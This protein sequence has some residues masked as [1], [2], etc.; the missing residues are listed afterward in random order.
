MNHHGPGDIGDSVSWLRIPTAKCFRND[1]ILIIL[2]QSSPV[3]TW[4]VWDNSGDFPA[5][6]AETAITASIHHTTSGEIARNESA[7]IVLTNIPLTPNVNG[8]IQFRISGMSS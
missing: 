6:D 5:A 3:L 8:L 4:G 1:H 7:A 2:S